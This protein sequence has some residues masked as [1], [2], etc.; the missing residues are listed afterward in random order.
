MNRLNLQK[1]DCLT[2]LLLLLWCTAVGHAQMRDWPTRQLDNT[3]SG[4]NDQ[5]TTLTQAS[6]LQNGLRVAVRI[7]VMGDARGMEAQPLIATNVP[8]AAGTHDVMFLPSMANVVRAVDAHDGTGIWQI[9]LGTPVTGSAQIDMHGIN[10]HWGAVGTGY[11]YRPLM[12]FLQ[13]AW[14]SRDGSGSPASGRYTLFQINAA[15]GTFAAAPLELQGT[16]TSLW[17]QRMGAA[18][19]V[20]NGRPYLHVG[21]SSVFETAGGLTGGMSAIDITANKVIA[22]WKT[23]A[24]LWGAGGGVYLGPD[25]VLRF[26][27]GNGLFDPSKGW[28]GES[29]M[30]LQF[31]G[32]AYKVLGN[33]TPWTDFQMTGQASPPAVK[34]S[35]ASLVTEDLKPSGGTMPGMASASLRNATLKATVDERGVPLMLVFPAN[36][37]GDNSD[38]DW[39]SAPMACIDAIK[40]CVAAGKHGVAYVMRMGA[41]GHTTAATV[42]TPANYGG[43]IGSRCAFVTASHGNGTSCMPADP[44]QLNSLPNGFTVHQHAPPVVFFDP[45]LKKWCVLFWGENSR[46]H[47]WTVDADGTLTFVAEGMEYASTD[48]RGNAPGGMPGGFGCGSSNGQ[49]PDT[50]LAAYSIPYNDA[51]A[52]LSAGRLLVYDPIHLDETGH[53][54]VLWDSQRFGIPYTHNK[55]MPCAIDGGQIVLPDYAGSVMIFR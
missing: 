30:E 7:P 21:H 51:N 13:V 2:L 18:V 27:T 36:A 34:L 35:G 17:K 41:F 28:Y 40:V 54:K 22:E 4:W 49:N 32:T 55:F 46:L 26:V 8:T 38:Q 29:G 20:L 14:I 48:S 44:R 9:T 42:G 39:G 1:I 52:R 43:L 31:T 15:D 3:R 23:T 16:D 47:K 33:F 19:Q 6:V 50:Y 24:G 25:G 53:L 12:R 11:F 37:Q 45:L 10:D 5:E